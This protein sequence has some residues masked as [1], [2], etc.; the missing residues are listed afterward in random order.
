MLHTASC[1]APSNQ[2][3]G[4]VRQSGDWVVRVGRRLWSIPLMRH[5]VGTE[6]T[7]VHRSSPHLQDGGIVLVGNHQSLLDI[8]AAFVACPTPIVFL[9]KA[10][11]RKVPLLEN[12]EMAGTVPRRT[13]QPQQFRKRWKQCPPVPRPAAC[14]SFEGTRSTT[15]DCNPSRKARFIWPFKPKHRWS[16][17]GFQEPMLCFRQAHGCCVVRPRL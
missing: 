10:S 5:V 13:Q 9:S 8:N 17:C 6:E 1:S 12:R 4:R 16:R 11:I 14:S 2:G 3:H 15:G 7:S